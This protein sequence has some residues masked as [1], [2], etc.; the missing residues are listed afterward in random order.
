[1]WRRKLLFMSGDL[2]VLLEVAYFVF[3][4]SNLLQAGHSSVRHPGKLKGE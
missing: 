3:T 1:M 2:L 4:S